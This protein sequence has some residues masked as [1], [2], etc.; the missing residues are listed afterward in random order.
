MEKLDRAQNAQF[1]G[2]KTWGRERGSQAPPPPDSLVTLLLKLHEMTIVIQCN[3][4]IVK[5]MIA[6]NK[7]NQKKLV[8]FGLGR[9]GGGRLQKYSA[10]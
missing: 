3:L 1:W 2:L 8:F 7:Y 10:P 6:D 9:G 5:R 4:W